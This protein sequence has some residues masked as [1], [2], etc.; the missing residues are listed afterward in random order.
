M[1]LSTNHQLRIGHL[2]GFIGNAKVMQKLLGFAQIPTFLTVAPLL[3]AS[4]HG[5]PLGNIGRTSR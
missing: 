5:G 3:R 2:V 4:Q 1:G